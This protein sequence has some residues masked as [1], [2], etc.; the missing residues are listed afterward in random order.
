MGRRFRRLHQAVTMLT[1]LWMR[2]MLPR[3]MAKSLMRKAK[4]P[5]TSRT[6]IVPMA[7]FRQ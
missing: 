7:P 4:G 5:V 3:T 1:M 2:M 6:S